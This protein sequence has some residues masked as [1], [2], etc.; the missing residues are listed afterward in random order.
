MTEE[1]IVAVRI[2]DAH[3]IVATVRVLGDGRVSMMRVVHEKPSVGTWRVELFL[4]DF[5]QPT[6]T[7]YC[8]RGTHDATTSAADVRDA[9]KRFRD[10]AGPQKVVAS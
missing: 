2:V 1:G 8:K 4:D 3:G 9:V 6:V 5:T 10:G 7:S